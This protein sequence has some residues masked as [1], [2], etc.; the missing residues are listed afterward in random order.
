LILGEPAIPE[1]L[2]R[3]CTPASLGATL[4]DVVRDGWA[5]DAQLHALSRLD[6][7]MKLAEG[8]APSAHAARAV[9]ETIEVRASR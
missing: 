8:G 1:F 3:G 9:L 7:L 6:R 5:R 4:A 2:Q